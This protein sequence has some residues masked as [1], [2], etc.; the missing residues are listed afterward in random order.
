[1]K[2][3]FMYKENGTIYFLDVARRAW[4]AKFDGSKFAQTRLRDPFPRDPKYRALTDVEVALPMRIAELPGA[5]KKMHL[6]RN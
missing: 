6:K 5:E 3:A 4:I 1:M 2:M